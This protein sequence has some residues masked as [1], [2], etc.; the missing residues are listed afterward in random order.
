VV[1][2]LWLM[3]ETVPLRCRR[4]APRARAARHRVPSSAGD[5]RRRLFARWPGPAAPGHL[6]LLDQRTPFG[7]LDLQPLGNLQTVATDLLQRPLETV[8]GAVRI[9]DRAKKDSLI[10]SQPPDLAIHLQHRD[11]RYQQRDEQNA[12][13]EVE[14]H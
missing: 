10:I 11:A 7:D 2:S 5:L 13:N 3:S 9:R 6:E 8:E 12:L 4:R 14:C 1:L